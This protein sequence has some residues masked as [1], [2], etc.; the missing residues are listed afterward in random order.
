MISAHLVTGRSSW[1][2]A[3]RGTIIEAPQISAWT[4]FGKQNWLRIIGVQ[5]IYIGLVTLKYM[6]PN[7]LWLPRFS[8][9]S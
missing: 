7:C 5:V 4:D 9:A 6:K 3:A 1:F 2:L 8:T